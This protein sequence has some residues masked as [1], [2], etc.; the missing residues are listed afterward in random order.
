[1][2]SKKSLRPGE[3]DDVA[4]RS[5]LFSGSLYWNLTFA[6]QRQPRLGRHRPPIVE[7]YAIPMPG[8]IERQT[9]DLWVHCVVD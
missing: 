5:R 4:S 2:L 9:V 7:I 6:Q 8:N 1:M 3:N